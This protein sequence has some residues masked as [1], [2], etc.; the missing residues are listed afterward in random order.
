MATLVGEGEDGMVYTR[1]VLIKRNRGL[2]NTAGVALINSNNRTVQRRSSRIPL[3][4]KYNVL[5]LGWEFAFT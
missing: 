5:L 4:P 2:R 1:S 3:I